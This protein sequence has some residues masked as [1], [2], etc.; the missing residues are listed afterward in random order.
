ML[1]IGRERN[2]VRDMNRSRGLIRRSNAIFHAFGRVA[3]EC[4]KWCKRAQYQP[5][6]PVYI[7]LVDKETG[8]IIIL[9]GENVSRGV[10]VVPLA[11]GMGCNNR[12]FRKESGGAQ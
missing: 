4:M 5:D 8:L 3:P 9:N 10:F 7:P 6:N 2:E 11:L 1:L 12:F